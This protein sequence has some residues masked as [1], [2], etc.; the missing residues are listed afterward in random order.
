MMMVLYSRTKSVVVHANVGDGWWFVDIF[1][2]DDE[3]NLFRLGFFVRV[4]LESCL[5]RR[6]LSLYTTTSTGRVN[7]VFFLLSCGFGLIGVLRKM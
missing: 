4:L 3:M 6:S 2:C 1:L 7:V 5:L